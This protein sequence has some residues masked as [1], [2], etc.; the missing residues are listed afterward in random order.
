MDLEEARREAGQR[1]A[2][3]R[4]V[5]SSPRVGILDLVF[6][7]RYLL[8]LAIYAL[9]FVMTGNG[10]RAA[11]LQRVWL[12]LPEV[13]AARTSVSLEQAIAGVTGLAIVC[14]VSA[15]LLRTWAA[16]YLGP[17]V[18]VS[19]KFEG[20]SIMAGGPYR[21]LRNPLYVG[22]VLHTIAICVLMSW[23][24]AIVVILLT[25]ALEWTLVMAE[26]RYLAGQMGDAYRSY[27][28]RVPRFFPS[29]TRRLGPGSGAARWGRAFLS[30]IYMWGAAFSFAAFGRTY[31][32]LLIMQGLVISFGIS[33]VV[34]GLLRGRGPA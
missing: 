21:F 14:A 18:V 8:H 15:A 25:L 34:R 28:E 33:I 22:I 5:K 1:E 20:A 29:P 4:E 17:E 32:A 2:G 12:W 30:E 3:Q 10:T 23:P 31:N 26:E 13:V 27:R 24:A 6:R 16:A 9:G 7:F 19:P 11:G